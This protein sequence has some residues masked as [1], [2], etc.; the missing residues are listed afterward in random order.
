[1]AAQPSPMGNFLVTGDKYG[2]I[3]FWDRNSGEMIVN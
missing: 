2:Q 3:H 1:M